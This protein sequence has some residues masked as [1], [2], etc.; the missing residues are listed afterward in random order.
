MHLMSTK[1]RRRCKHTMNDTN[2]KLCRGFFKIHNTI[3]VVINIAEKKTMH[4]FEPSLVF[5]VSLERSYCNFSQIFT[6]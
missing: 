2:R 5:W 6:L 3:S 4:K 1:Y